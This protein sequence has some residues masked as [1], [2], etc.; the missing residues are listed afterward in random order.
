MHGEHVLKV[1]PGKRRLRATEREAVNNM[2]NE[3]ISSTLGYED[4]PEVRL[5][6]AQLIDSLASSGKCALSR[7]VAEIAVKNRIWNDPLQRPHQ[8][9]V[10]AIKGAP[11]VD[12]S[13]FWFIPYLEQNFAGILREI[14]AVQDP[15]RYGFTAVDGPYEPFLY[16]GGKWDNAILYHD[17]FRFNE[18]C[19]M[20]PFTSGVLKSIPELTTDSWGLAYISWLY[21][22]THIVPHCG[23]SNGRLRVHM[24]I[25]IPSGTK[26]RVGDQEFVWTPGK[27]VV[28]DDSFEHEVWHNGHEP[29][30]VLILDFLHPELEASE[31]AKIMRTLRT[32]Q[33]D[34]I[35]EFLTENLIERLALNETGE[36]IAYPNASVVE[37]V[38]SKMKNL[39]LRSV[40]NESGSLV[41]ERSESTS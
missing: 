12:P 10:R 18:T 11:L 5:K 32:S 30:I 3:G 24:G 36:V 17:G 40:Q 23:P 9:F 31:R 4:A 39:G 33:E 34:K 25:K 27:C 21:P 28:I 41:V 16:K 19:E 22:G 37:M 7:E 20:F 15:E 8:H 38:K 35:L 6:F 14:E 13:E 1:A 2:A 29:R 26:M